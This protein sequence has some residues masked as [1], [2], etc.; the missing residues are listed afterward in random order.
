M[1]LATICSRIRRDCL[2]FRSIRLEVYIRRLLVRLL[3]DFLWDLFGIF[4][5]RWDWVELGIV[6]NVFIKVT[7]LA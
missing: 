1:L 5:I 2:D 7:D 3:A 6:Y 4:G